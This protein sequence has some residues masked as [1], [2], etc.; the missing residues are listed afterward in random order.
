MKPIVS[1]C[2]AGNVHT[3]EST[4]CTSCVSAKSK[5]LDRNIHRAVFV[6][7]FAFESKGRFPE[8]KLLFFWILSKFVNA[9]IEQSPCKYTQVTRCL[10]TAQY[11]CSPLG[12]I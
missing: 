10:C 3:C 5:T 6:F 2:P 11:V 12:Y 7:E 9:A 8:K 4:K 1:N